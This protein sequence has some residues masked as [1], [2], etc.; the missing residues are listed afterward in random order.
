MNT[1]EYIAREKGI[2]ETMA[3]SSSC[4]AS[5]NARQGSD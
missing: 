4:I 5:S 1:K 2:D 3:D